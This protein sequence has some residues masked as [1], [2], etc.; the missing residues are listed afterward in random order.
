MPHRPSSTPRPAPTSWARPFDRDRDAEEVLAPGAGCR[1]PAS[2]AIFP[3]SLESLARHGHREG[4]LGPGVSGSS[5]TTRAASSAPCSASAA[6]RGRRARGSSPVAVAD[7]AR[8]RGHGHTLVRLLLDE[9]RVA[10]L[11]HAEASAHGPTAASARVFEVAGLHVARETERWEK[12]L[13]VELAQIAARARETGRLG[14]NGVPAGGPLSPA[15]L[16]GP[17]RRR[18]RDP[19]A[20]PARAGPR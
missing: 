6:A 11:R 13:G 19:P 10:K 4:G 8:G 2:R 16:P 14:T 9:F 7:R 5:S 3:Q 15:P 18:R 1:T 12:V 17:D 20:R